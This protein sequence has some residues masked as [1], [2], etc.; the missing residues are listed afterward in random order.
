MSATDKPRAIAG[1]YGEV[2]LEVGGGPFKVD[3]TSRYTH[4]EPEFINRFE[5]KGT[6]NVFGVG[7]AVTDK[8]DP[9]FKGAISWTRLYKYGKLF[10]D[11]SDRGKSI[12]EARKNID[13]L[14]QAVQG[15]FSDPKGLVQQ[16]VV[17]SYFSPKVTAAGKFG[18]VFTAE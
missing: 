10:W 16:N 14:R 3:I 13:E 6:I 1:V 5:T 2:K 9:T 8:G 4:N 12:V 18:Y 11:L 7:V 17:K 15:V